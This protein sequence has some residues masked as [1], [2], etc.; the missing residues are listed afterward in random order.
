MKWHQDNDSTQWKFSQSLSSSKHII[1]SVVT[2]KLYLQQKKKTTKK[3]LN[4]KTRIQHVNSPSTSEENFLSQTSDQ[5]TPHQGSRTIQYRNIKSESSSS[6]PCGTKR[7]S[8]ILLDRCR[9]SCLF[10][11]CLYNKSYLPIFFLPFL[12]HWTPCFPV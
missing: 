8:Q 12:L 1:L 10:Q 9:C 3:I 11:A 6:I 2:Y 5:N 7:S 4:M